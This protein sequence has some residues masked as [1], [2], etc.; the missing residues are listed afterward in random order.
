MKTRRFNGKRLKEALQLREKK[1]TELANET[2][3]SK[4]S[5]SLYANDGNTP[6]FENVVKIADVLRFP[7]DFFMT[8]D[9]FSFTG[10]SNKEI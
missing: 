2:G 3:I 6:P 7:A 1:M 10:C 8:E 5:L 4:Q 9:L